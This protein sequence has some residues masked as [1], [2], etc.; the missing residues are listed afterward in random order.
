LRPNASHNV[1]VTVLGGGPA[2]SA[3]ALALC[4]LGYSVAMIEK[5]AY[6]N[7]R[8]G[9]T[10]PPDVQPLL[11]SLGVWDQFLGQQHSP[12]LGIRTAWGRADLYEQ[13]F[14]FNP[15]G[16]GWYLNRARFDWMLAQAANQMGAIQ[17]RNA[18]LVDLA[19]H[20]G[21]GWDLT[22]ACVETQLSFRTKFM[23]DAT[24]RAAT[25][26]RRQGS[27]RLVYDHLIGVV[28]FLPKHSSRPMAAGYTLI[29]GTEYGWW[30]AASLP[31]ASIV[32]MLMT[33]ADLYAEASRT[34]AHYWRDLLE[35]SPHTLAFLGSTSPPTKL[36][37]V[38][39]NS[40]RL[41]CISR[42]NWLAVGDAAVAF[43]PLSSQGVYN[44]LESGLRAAQA[45][46][47]RFMGQ[48]DALD[49]WDSALRDDFRRYLHLREHYYSKEKRWAYSEFWH[50]RHVA[51][52]DAEAA[53]DPSQ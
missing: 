45:I 38:A 37:I 51:A 17:W 13:N 4:R 44:A 39:A 22:V 9:E 53:I 18:R 46:H 16:S 3:T 48:S 29:E 43:D 49:K 31:D 24:G 47:D 12:S 8:I 41:D 5:T 33:D 6:D 30:Y 20:G 21:D 27:R 52:F 35:K 40:S 26:A 1:D 10:L 19:D 25:L 7:Q 34:S 32:A 28:G 50:R 2:G 23:V 15:Y 14:I 36:R 42:K 11:V